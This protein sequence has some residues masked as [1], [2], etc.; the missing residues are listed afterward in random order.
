MPFA[1]DYTDAV[2]PSLENVKSRSGKPI[3]KH[4]NLPTSDQQTAMDAFVSALD[5][6]NA[7][8]ALSLAPNSLTLPISRS[9]PH[10]AHTLD[11]FPFPHH[12]F[13]LSPSA[14]RGSRDLFPPSLVHPRRLVQAWHPPHEGC[15]LLPDDG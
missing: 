6:S 14:Q 4:I 5:L 15:H 7:R 12:S 3:D 10:I 11:S 8:Y 1:D 2:F 13:Y 9:F